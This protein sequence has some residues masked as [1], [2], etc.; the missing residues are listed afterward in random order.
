MERKAEVTVIIPNYNG[1]AYIEDC[2]IFLF[3][4]RSVPFETIVVDDASTDGSDKKVADRFGRKVRLIRHSENCGFAKAVNTG[5]RAAD[6]RYVILLNNDTVP[7][8]D[9]VEKLLAA[10]KGKRGVFS[11]SAGMLSMRKPELIDGMGDNYCALGWAY[12]VGK[13]KDKERYL[14][15]KPVFSACGGAAIYDRK[16]LEKLGL[17]DELHFAYLEDVDIGYR[18]RIYGYRNLSCPE[19]VVYHVGSASSGSRYNEFKVDLSSRNSIYLIAKNMP[20]LQV[21]INLP[22][23]LAGYLIKII[24]FCNK[25]LGGVYIRGLIKGFRL[26]ASPEGREKRVRFSMKR[27]HNYA[28]IQLLLWLNV[29]RRFA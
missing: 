6:T 22:L 3:R 2:L 24:F 13:G 23:L 14:R 4:N 28:S 7:E 17:F 25:R 16:V 1:K 20:P 15:K 11:V 29:F 9:F 12:A 5:I 27:L 8:P 10:I 21:I 18:A 26:A 19:A